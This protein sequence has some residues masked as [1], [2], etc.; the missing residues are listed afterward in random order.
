M[1]ACANIFC[2]ICEDVY[3]LE[4][5]KPLLLPCSHTFCRTCL[6]QLKSTNNDLCPLCRASWA[7][8]SV[9]S[10]P[11]VRQLAVSSDKIS[12]KTKV[13]S[14]PNQ[15]ICIEHNSKLIAW[16]KI[17]KVPICIDCVNTGHKSCGWVSIKKK[18]AELIN[19]LQESVN[20]TRT[21]LNEKFTH[22]TDEHI[23]LLTDTKANIQKMQHYEKIIESFLKQLSITQ[24]NAMKKLEEYENI[25]STSNVTDLTIAISAT[26]SLI[27]DPIT[28]PAIPNVVVPYSEIHTND[29]DSEY[30]QD[31][32]VSTVNSI[33]T[34]ISPVMVR[35]AGIATTISPVMVRPAGIATTSPVM[36][37]PAGIATTSPVIVR[38]DGIP[39]ASPVMV[40][41][42]GIATTSPGMVRPAGIATTSPVIVR[43]DGIATTYLPW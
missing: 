40:R 4:E 43:P 13:Q 41:P 24:E 15:N 10:L 21:K 36:V 32:E 2:C 23:S 37:R 7:C 3:N 6:L 8:Q 31:G 18:T 35:P 34:T 20:S 26:L 42:N 27:D 1:A 12:T 5:K 38:P 28:I 30:Q 19:N 39:T 16:C 25:K 11:F 22:I 29:T 33:A 17:C 14:S 9:D